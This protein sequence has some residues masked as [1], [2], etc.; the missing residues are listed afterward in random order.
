MLG[1][2]YTIQ[3]RKGKE[4]T[5]A[6]ILLRKEEQGSYKGRLVIGEDDQLKRRIL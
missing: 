5:M 3:Y 1:M 6:D 4:N 2:D